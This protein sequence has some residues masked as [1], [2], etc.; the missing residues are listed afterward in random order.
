MPLRPWRRMSPPLDD[1]SRGTGPPLTIARAGS[2]HG[3]HGA[4]VTNR[5][6][7][8]NDFLPCGKA[9]ATLG[10]PQDAKNH[11]HGHGLG[12]ALVGYSS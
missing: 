5:G 8:T 9:R 6:W 1:R 3:G 11:T 4:V 12:V 10:I 7:D 2:G